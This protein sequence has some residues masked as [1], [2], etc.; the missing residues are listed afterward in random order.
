M[1][2]HPVRTL[3]SGLGL[4]EGPVH[5]ASG[6]GIVVASI[7]LG[8]VYSI[9]RDGSCQLVGVPGGGPNGLAE[10]ADG[11]LYVAQN[12]GTG[13]SLRTPGVTGGVQVLHPD[14]QVRQLT[15]DPVSPNDICI[16]PGG[17]LYLTDPTRPFPRADGRLWRVDPQSG[18][19]ELLTSVAYYP[20]GIGFGTD[21]DAL[22]VADTTAARI[23]RYRLDAD[24]RDAGEVVITMEHGR[25]DG[26]CFDED[27]NL[28]VAASSWEDGPGSVQT[29]SIDGVLLDELP[30][31]PSVEPTNVA[32]SAHRQLV[33]TDSAG[34][35]VLVVDDWP[36]AGLALHP[37]RSSRPEAGIVSIAASEAS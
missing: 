21:S 35:C 11:E 19:S 3:V 24:A 7:E 13:R 37:F 20:N 10:G 9:S 36:T 18:A 31:A 23:V 27:G 5:V 25:P 26:F 15:S 16:G 28:L 6:V 12:G 29:W 14:G 32:L 22:Y 17:E 4:T 8:H 2:D 34:G 33:I 1:S 30:L